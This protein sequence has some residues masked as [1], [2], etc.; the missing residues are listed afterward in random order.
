MFPVRGEGATLRAVHLPGGTATDVMADYRTHITTSGILGAGYG[1]AATF[2]AGFTP[3]QGALAGVLTGIAGMLPDL[4][5]DS[6]R[7]VREVFSLVA[8]VSPLLLYNRLEAWGGGREPAIL[9]AVLVYVAIRYGA[10]LLLQLLSVHRGMF[11]SVPAL[12]IASAATFLA[13]LGDSNRIRGLMALGVALGFLSHLVLDEFYSVRWNGA[14]LQLKPSA[15]SA[16]KFLGKS[17]PANI[18]AWGVALTLGY[19]AVID[20]GTEGSPAS[21]KAGVSLIDRTANGSAVSPSRDRLVNPRR[22]AVS[23]SPSRVHR[24]RRVP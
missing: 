19:A 17:W 21:R 15:G 6:G 1:V 4:D 22:E 20:A 18:F 3:V 5:S 12:V 8:A 11:H 2:G 24:P 13:Y 16:V 10:A 7:P 23:P 14:L 9:L